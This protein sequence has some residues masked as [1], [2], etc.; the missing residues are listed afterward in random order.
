M[1]IALVVN[2]RSRSAR[3]EAVE[4][5]LWNFG[6]DVERFDV[7]A[8][9]SA[10][11]S[12][13]DRL[14]VAGGDGSIGPAAAAA[15]RSGLPLAVIPAGTANDFARRMRLP[16]RLEDA[17]WL[18]VQ[19]QRLQALELGT[20][21]AGG[22]PS[23]ANGRPFVNVASLGLP[24]PAAARARS[25]KR[26]LGQ[27]AYAL[28]ALHAGLTADPVRCRVAC[29]GRVL[30]DGPAWQV[31]VACSGAFGAGSS[32][33]GADPADGLL[34]VVAIP[35]GSRLRL[36]GLAYALRRE[37]LPGRTGVP[38]ARGRSAE[39]DAPPRATFNVDG[40]LVAAGPARFGVQPGAF[41]LVAG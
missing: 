28:G 30:H 37:R 24:A 35:A 11:A 25:W 3:P 36:P 38:H 22:S 14:A 19:G 5:A 10:A 23:L 1:R 6:A 26:A 27:F 4:A 29:D 40:E 2:S 32:L 8:A 34:D 41:Q 16:R 12:R 39:V 13:P 9:G 20:M 15:G 18:A 21:T 7:D 17:C 33:E 31:T